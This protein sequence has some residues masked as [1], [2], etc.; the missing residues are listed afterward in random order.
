VNFRSDLYFILGIVSSGKASYVLALFPYVVLI[1][2]FIRTITLP[3][4]WDGI[5]IFF[6]PQWEKMLDY[7]VWFDAVTQVFFSLNI[8]FGCVNMFASYNKF[9]HNIYRDINVISI[10]DTCTSLLA[11]TITFGIL[12]HIKYLTG[13]D[14]F[15]SIEGGPG[16]AF[17]TY[18]DALAKFTIL[19]QLFA[20]LFFLMLVSL[21]IGSITSMSLCAISVIRDKYPTLQNWKIALLATTLG[22]SIG[23]IYLTPVIKFFS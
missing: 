18:P 11:G 21:G 17:V 5:V 7:N 10:L 6:N 9:N 22:F 2:L 16:L 13:E 20:V 8:C 19:P 14:V 3:G 1:I 4:V 15:K 23:N 12:G